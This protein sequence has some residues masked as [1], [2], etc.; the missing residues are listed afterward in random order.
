MQLIYCKYTK[1]KQMF[2]LYLLTELHTR[3]VLWLT[4]NCQIY[5]V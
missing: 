1:N 4:V 5:F 3:C 2:N